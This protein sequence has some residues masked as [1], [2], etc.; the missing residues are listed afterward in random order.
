V[1]VC[2]RVCVCVCV[3]VYDEGGALCTYRVAVSFQ[4][5]P[6]AHSP[7]TLRMLT[8]ADVC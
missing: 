2:V 1:C 6:L 8:Y 5:H 4:T 3:C 7:R